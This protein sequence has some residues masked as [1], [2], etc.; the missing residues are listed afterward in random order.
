[1]ESLIKK[2]P[3]EQGRQGTGYNKIKLFESKKWRYDG[4]LLYYPEGS[5][6]PSHTDPVAAGRHYRL[7]IML[8][9]AKKG[10]EFICAD[11]VFKCWRMSLFRPDVS[12]HAVSRIERG[13]RIM[14][15]IGWVRP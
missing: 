12:P 6:I 9:K 8:K 7:N 3:W 10:G 13:Y 5:E 14:L 15:S 1:M 4:Y 11:P 2:L